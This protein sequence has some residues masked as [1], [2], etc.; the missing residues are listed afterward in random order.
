MDPALPPAP[1]VVPPAPPLAQS[2]MAACTQVLLPSQLSV[3]HPSPSSQSPA[4]SQQPASAVLL[5]T[6]PEHRSRVQML[7]S[8][9]SPLV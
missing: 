7:L 8:A 2:T 4:V 1:D 9:Q 3:V 6:S 5:H